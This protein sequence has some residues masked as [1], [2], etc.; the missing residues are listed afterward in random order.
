MLVPGTDPEQSALAESGIIGDPAFQLNVVPNAVMPDLQRQALQDTASGDLAKAAA[1]AA[2]VEEDTGS[3][4]I[5]FRTT[6]DFWKR[7]DQ[8]EPV[9]VLGTI[10]GTRRGIPFIFASETYGN[11]SAR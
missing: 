6:G 5:D 10:E 3:V 2:P 8:T 4:L 11:L 7:I 1:E 9:A